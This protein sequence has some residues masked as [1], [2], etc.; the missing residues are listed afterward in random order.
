M[1]TC[2]VHYARV[3]ARDSIGHVKKCFFGNVGSS[4][5]GGSVGR[6]SVFHA[7]DVKDVGSNFTLITFFFLVFFPFFSD[8]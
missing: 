3:T 4:V 2:Y 7:K 5:Q 8:S 1:A 6:A